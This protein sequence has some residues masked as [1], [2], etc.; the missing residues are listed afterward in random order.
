MINEKSCPKCKKVK[1]RSEFYVA[2]REASG[3]QCWCKECQKIAGQNLV[4][5]NPE[6][7]M[8]R[9]RRWRKA[10]TE[11][12]NAYGAKN[13]KLYPAFHAAR[14]MRQ[15]AIKLRAIPSWANQ[16]FIDEIYDLAARR[17]AIKCG[18]IKKWDV[19]HIVPLK[20]PLICGLHVHNNLRVIPAT[21][22]YKKG[23]RHWPDMP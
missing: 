15:R 13:R 4:K 7:Q 18:G 9:T 11:K 21:D 20:S 8:D 23:N 1:L 5:K 12:H 14:S 22:N 6:R 16:F 2:S 10:N 19:D 17:S 3:L